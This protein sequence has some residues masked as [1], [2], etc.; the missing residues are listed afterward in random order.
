MGDPTAEK[1]TLR[2]EM[3]AVRRALPDVADRSQR[4]WT[5]VTALGAVVD[6]DV[7]MAFDSIPGEPDTGPLVTWCEADGTRVVMPEDDPAPDPAEVDVVIVPG[8][9]FTPDGDRLGQGGGWYDRFLAEVRADCTVIGVG[10]S[11]QLVDALPTEA[12]DR[13]VHLVVTEQGLAA[14]AT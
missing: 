4:I 7:L 6:A 11:P 3:R 1:R 13:R 10:F 2:A 12:H 5:A 14:P 9:A 8:I